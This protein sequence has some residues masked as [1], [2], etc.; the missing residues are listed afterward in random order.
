MQADLVCAGMDVQLTLTAI[1]VP[2]RAAHGLGQGHA[3]RGAHTAPSLSLAQ[4]SK[5]ALPTAVWGGGVITMVTRT[6]PP[7]RPTCPLLTTGSSASHP[8]LLPKGTGCGLQFASAAVRDTI[9]AT[10]RIIEA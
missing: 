4:G 9:A 10:H 3:L 5:A 1:R 2:V 8:D 6:Y 7:V